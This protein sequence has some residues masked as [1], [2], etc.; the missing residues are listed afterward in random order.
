MVY[1][2][3]CANYP[4]KKEVLDDLVNS[5]LNYMANANANHSLGQKAKT[6]VLECNN[7]IKKTLNLSDDVDIIHTSSA[8]ESNNM[9]IKGIIESYNAFGKKI[10]VSQLEHNSINGCLS[11]YKESGYEIDFIKTESTGHISIK[12]LESKLD[13]NVILVIVT[14][15]DGELGTLQDYESISTLVSK[16]KNAHLLMDATQ[17][18]A[19]YSIDFNKIEMV[20]FSPHKFGGLT[21]TG[22]LLKKKSTI[23]APLINGGES[24]TIYRSGS[25][26]VGLISQATK[27]I[28]LVVSNRDDNVNCLKDLS[29]YLLTKLKSIRKIEINSFENLFIFNIGVNG[30][31][32]SNVVE[33]LSS[34][35]IYVSQKSACSIKNTPSKIIMSVY[36]DKKRALESFRVSISELTTKDEIDI[37]VRALEEL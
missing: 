9:A 19:K 18:I 4:I 31:K 34:K 12:D 28:E 8:T 27:A 16:Y 10:L 32:S 1:L 36:N 7:R 17:A 23:L 15:L 33:Y 22:V 37:W 30:I 29:K 3:Y 6:Y 14:I 20:S 26:P 2:D 24:L 35:D 11:S 21:G 5:E 25:I 13:D